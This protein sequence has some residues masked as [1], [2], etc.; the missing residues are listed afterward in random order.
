[1]P[2]ISIINTR[3]KELALDAIKKYQRQL[4]S[5][6]PH[7]SSNNILESPELL[8]NLTSHNSNP[9]CYEQIGSWTFVWEGIEIP[10]FELVALSLNALPF[11]NLSAN[12]L[13]EWR[14][15]LFA[16]NF[17]A[18]FFAAYNHES[19]LIV[20]AND[21]LARLPVYVYHQ[22]G[23]LYISREYSLLRLLTPTLQPDKEILAL[24][25]LFGYAP[26]FGSPFREID[27]LKC[28]TAACYNLANDTSVT[29]SDL[30]RRLPV[31]VKQGSKKARLTELKTIFEKATELCLNNRPGV[32][33]LSGGY[34]SRS[35]AAA[36][37]NNKSKFCSAT[38]Q[39]TDNTAG[40]DVSSA[41]RL[42][43]H[44]N[45]AHSNLKLPK[46]NPS[47]YAALF[48]IKHGLNYMGVAFLIS[49]LQELRNHYG[50]DFVLL[51]GDGGDKVVSALLPFK[52]HLNESNVVEYIFEHNAVFKRD[53]VAKLLDIPLAS[54]EDY[55]LN[56]LR[57]YPVSDWN[58][59]YRYFLLAERGGRW[60]FE[61]EDRNRYY[62]AS[63]TPFY[64]L[65]FYRSAL[66]IPPSWKDN[67]SFYLEF[68]KSIL[69][70]VGNT[71]LADEFLAPN[72][73]GYPFL[74]ALLLKMR[75]CNLISKLKNNFKKQPKTSYLS[76]PFVQDRAN[77]LGNSDA[78]QRFFFS[79]QLLSSLLLSGDMNRLQLCNLYTV[80]TMLADEC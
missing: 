72:D 57:S 9:L 67:Q 44:L 62:C 6:L 58:D 68:M 49:F 38:Y 73:F 41:C 64:D 20:L 65:R 27:T 37:L 18:F 33:A 39:D 71:S 80:L 63:E 78:V 59:K 54:L 75:R 32:L 70:S 22:N 77:T 46:D 31:I 51:T 16:N 19:R 11:D 10:D 69:P 26:G 3:D 35:V 30:T 47:L 25:L 8:I 36:L 40:R 43:Q 61:G 79:N 4:A 74:Q 7:I 12:V 42:A 53:I 66:S 24:Y 17:S 76:Q 50:D 21:D 29:T 56:L 5:A 14:D 13:R 15:K 45:I 48:A 52:A 28:S 1:M 34:D 55:L 60:L 23:V 2:G